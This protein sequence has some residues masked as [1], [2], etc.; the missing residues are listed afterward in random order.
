LILNLNPNAL[1]NMLDV[2]ELT[3]SRAACEQADAAD[4]LRSWREKFHLPEGLIYLD[5]NSLGPLPKAAR[6]DLQQ[7]IEQEWAEDLIVS[8][9]KAG[10]WELP[11]TL[12]E[13]LAPVLGA[14]AG[15]TV[16]VDSVSLN[17]FKVV[18]AALQLRPGRKVIVS[19]ADG[20]PT[21]LYMLEGIS[22]ANPGVERR[23]LG[24]DGE[25]FE[26]LLDEQV[27]VV[28]VSH[29]NFRTGEILDIA[30]LAKKVHAAGALLVVDVCHT[31]GVV[32]IECDAWEL[33]FVVG[34]TYKY[35][36]AGPGAPAFLYAARRH[37]AEALNPLPGWWSHARPFAFEGD[38]AP[39]A[40]IK[41]FCTGTQPILSFR[42]SQAG[43]E[44]AAQADLGQVREKS[45]RLTQLFL[46]LSKRWL[47][48]FG[49]GVVSPEAPELRG[50]Q[51]SLYFENGFPVVRALIARKIIGD[52]RPPGLMR[53]GFAPLYLR[54]TDVWDAATALREVLASGEWQDERFQEPSAVT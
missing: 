32:P 19:E 16:V 18:H 2:T 29:V 26:E 14:A 52:F 4:P 30:E 39:V 27:A 33:D 54:H 12:G 46:E 13:V 15:Q 31:A 40:G 47:A 25:T 48:E 36:N 3:Q 20:F 23:L 22:G 5:G 9:N 24:R 11:G 42:G 53:F 8:W 21:D 38:Y 50:S 28:V 6:A 34:C 51:V 17:L 43:L 44:I 49:V 41:R 45:Q 10:W 7:T 35:L 1:S 37:L